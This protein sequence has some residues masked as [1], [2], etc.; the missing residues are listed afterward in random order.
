ME[1]QSSSGLR[2]R[3][4]AI[5]PIQH[6]TNLTSQP[7]APESWH[8]AQGTPQPQQ[9]SVLERTLLEPTPE[10]SGYNLGTLKP[11]I[12]RNLVTPTQPLSTIGMRYS[13]SL[14]IDMN[15]LNYMHDGNFYQPYKIITLLPNSPCNFRSLKL[16]VPDNVIHKLLPT[17]LVEGHVP[18]LVEVNFFQ[19]GLTEIYNGSLK[20]LFRVSIN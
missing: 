15:Y 20:T 11:E 14:K 3:N 10:P 12:T 4:F 9:L 19:D 18:R 1:N 17:E 6:L 8:M 2:L 16:C 13:E 7:L 5:D